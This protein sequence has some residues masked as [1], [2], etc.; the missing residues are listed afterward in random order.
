N[1]GDTRSALAS[2]EKALDIRK[3]VD[4]RSKD[5]NDRLALA[6][7][8]RL[9][10]HQLWATGDVPSARERI[11]HAIAISEELN[12]A[13][14][15]DP[16]V[17]YEVAFDHEVSGEV[18]YP[19]D[20]LENQKTAEDFRKALAADEATLKILPDDIRTL[21]GYAVD[22]HHL[23]DLLEADDPNAGLANYE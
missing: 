12:V 3:Q 16:K 18:R 4:A 5:W 23:G 10:A 20:P 9:V 8:Y 19:G 15:N 7:A 11:N 14:P 22:F 17:L 21:H 2:Y 13:R 1:L 6:Q